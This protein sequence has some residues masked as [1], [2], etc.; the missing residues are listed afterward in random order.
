MCRNVDHGGRRC[1]N[2]NSAARRIRRVNAGLKTSFSSDVHEPIHSSTV[3][4]ENLVP[5][6]VEATV[7]VVDIQRAIENYNDLKELLWGKEGESKVIPDSMVVD[8]VIYEN[9][10]DYF[11]AL[12]AKV[13]QETVRL[14][15]MIA[16]AA[17]QR[18]GF[19]D[20][21]IIEGN[22]KEVEE[23]EASWKKAG[24]DYT[25][26]ADELHAKYRIN[27]M[28]VSYHLSSKLEMTQ[29][30]IEEAKAEGTDFTP[31]FS[32]EE[33]QA[34]IDKVQ[35]LYKDK[36]AAYNKVRDT[37][38]A[39]TQVAREQMEA[40]RKEQLELLKELRPLG[41]DVVVHVKSNPQKVKV[42]QEA[43][44]FV[45]AEWVERSNVTGS[46]LMVKKTKARAHYSDG[47]Y[48]K[49]YKVVK[50]GS[51]S[52]MKDGAVP[53]NSRYQSGWIKVEADE[54]GLVKYVDEAGVT[55]E[56]WIEPNETAYYAP[57]WEYYYNYYDK[58]MSYSP[59]KKP[60][61]RGWEFATVIDS[62]FDYETKTHTPV[63][64]G[65]W[66]RRVTKRKLISETK[67][68]ELLIDGDGKY[69]SGLDTAIHE[70]M[71]RVEA[72]DPRVG[73]L[74][75]AFIKRR[76]TKE[77]GTQEGIIRIYKGKNEFARPDNF[78]DNYMGKH[79]DHSNGKHWEVLSTGAE[80]LWTGAF[81]GFM[82]VGNNKPDT[83]HRNFVLGIFAGL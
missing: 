42:L 76:T 77:D 20:E 30:R 83:D 23:A 16:L 52:I 70:F 31:E 4:Q 74:E 68:A 35:Q 67:T 15:G 49:E 43:L 28:D 82:G 10:F 59:D 63:E 9:S 14:G 11:E 3:N 50:S 47:S 78:I 39:G 56:R 33:M 72:K 27:A 5:Q 8:G 6:A 22:R 2:D 38:S 12:K 41:G 61:G 53:D 46:D 57:K 75:S 48:Q 44:G 13:E 60:S 55:H 19:T 21:M 32:V 7:Q 54:D 79:Y 36:D 66:R 40:N 34:D 69:R 80:A 29:G 18:T 64:R 51:L 17:S 25:S 1:P 26:F 62:D 45:P 71:H 73:L 24:E 37:K 81:G 65:V 58:D